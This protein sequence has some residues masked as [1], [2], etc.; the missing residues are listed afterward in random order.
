MTN[1]HLVPYPR[2]LT[3]LLD[4]GRTTGCDIALTHDENSVT[5][6][7]DWARDH[8]AN[9]HASTG[10]LIQQM[11][12]TA[13]PAY[14]L[15]DSDPTPF[16]KFLPEVDFYAFRGLCRD[17]LPADEFAIVDD[18]YTR[19]FRAVTADPL[20]DDED[21]SLRI[22]DMLSS[23]T[24]D[25]E[26]TTIIRATQAALFKT[27]RHLYVWMP[28]LRVAMQR[29]QHRRTDTSTIASRAPHSHSEHPTLTG[30]PPV[31]R[32]SSQTRV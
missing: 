16:P 13:R 1:A 4:L 15:P 22:R 29:D 31:Q 27:G 6:V 12:A 14:P 7:V 25:S 9:I 2:L 3:F 24:S 5:P 30:H 11:T 17:L 28:T 26:A 20:G 21:A 10:P 23:V 18:L 8:G 32:G 19:T